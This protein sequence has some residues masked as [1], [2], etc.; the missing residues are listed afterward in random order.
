MQPGLASQQHVLVNRLA[1]RF[2]PPHR[3]DV[4]VLH[5]PGL[6]SSDCIKRIIGLPGEHVQIDKGQVLIDGHPLEEPYVERD[7]SPGTPFPNQWLL[8]YDQYL[9]LGDWRQDSRDSRS[10]GPIRLGHVVGKAWIRYWPLGRW[11]QLG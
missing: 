10:F 7:K 2:T 6:P 1:Y 5:D 8:D 4:V 3:G 9:V 11:K